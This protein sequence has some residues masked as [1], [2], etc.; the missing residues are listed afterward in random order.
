MG[1]NYASIMGCIRKKEADKKFLAIKNIIR[2]LD[3]SPEDAKSKV[4]ANMIIRIAEG[5]VA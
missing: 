4:A 1:R 3:A 2:R 5:R